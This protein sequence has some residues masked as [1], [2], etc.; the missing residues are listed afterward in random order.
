MNTIPKGMDLW[1]YYPTPGLAPFAPTKKVPDGCSF[2]IH[3]GPWGFQ[4]RMR[5]STTALLTAQAVMS[6]A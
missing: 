1:E 4:S 3:Q 5:Y 2:A 6:T